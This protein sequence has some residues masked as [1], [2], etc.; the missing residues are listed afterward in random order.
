MP[1]YTSGTVTYENLPSG[2]GPGKPRI[3][4][5]AYA[6]SVTLDWATADIFE[7]TLTGNI[8]ITHSGGA[9]NGEKKEIRLIQDGTGSRVVT[10]AN[11]T[12]GS[13]VMST[14]SVA[15]VTASKRD[16]WIFEYDSGNTTYTMVSAARGY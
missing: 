6:A 14:S 11:N 3:S 15:T 7:I 9:N 10:W 16:K 4:T 2:V 13:D 1:M 8:T 5:V 12:Y